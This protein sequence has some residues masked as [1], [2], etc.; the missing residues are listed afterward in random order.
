MKSP[1]HKGIMKVEVTANP[2]VAELALSFCT[3][4]TDPFE[5]PVEFPNLPVVET[6][7]VRNAF[8]S[9]SEFSVPF[10]VFVVVVRGTVAAAV[11]T[12]AVVTPA[13][14]TLAVVTRAVVTAA[15]VTLAVVA[16]AVVTAE[17]IVAEAEEEAV[18]EEA[19][20]EE[21]VV[22]EA[23]VEEAVVEEAVVDAAESV[24][25]G[26]VSAEDPV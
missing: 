24:E 7:P 23:V 12:P 16:R 14:V 4:I 21:A 3:L 2:P 1:M 18:V 5:D 19:V 22:E 8:H 13:V 20:V 25:E 15:V 10:V 11:V 6:E 26:E 17:E 9:D